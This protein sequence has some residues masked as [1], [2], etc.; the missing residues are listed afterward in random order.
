MSTFIDR[1]KEEATELENK[2]MKLG[3]FIDNNPTF[4]E[5]DEIQQHLLSIQY[6][7]MLTY[8]N[9]LGKRIYFLTK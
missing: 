3:D 6:S 2:V 8:L 9:L 5:I 4:H 1:L 7:T